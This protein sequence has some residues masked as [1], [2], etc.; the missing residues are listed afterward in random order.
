MKY[1]EKF[2][3][4]FLVLVVG[5]IAP[6]K[7]KQSQKIIWI[8]NYYVIYPGLVEILH[9]FF[10]ALKFM[11]VASSVV[12]R[13]SHS[14]F[15]FPAPPN[16]QSPRNRPPSPSSA[17]QRPPSPQPSSR[18]PPIQRPALTPTGPPT[19]RKRDSKP[20]ESAP[21]QPVTPQPAETPPPGNTPSGKNKDG[22]WAGCGVVFCPVRSLG[23]LTAF[24]PRRALRPLLRQPTF[25]MKARI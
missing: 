7:I 20:K 24:S 12:P 14:A 23:R 11:Q 22:E 17:K 15:L 13:T 6:G 19:L 2:R 21:G 25:S 4:C 10:A 9:T 5:S 1:Y 3:P 18:P 8:Q 16:R